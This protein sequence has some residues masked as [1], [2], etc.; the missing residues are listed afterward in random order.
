LNAF[1]LAYVNQILDGNL[2]I[3]GI[4]GVAMKFGFD[5]NNLDL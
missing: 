4:T 2:G 5:H 3:L 1:S